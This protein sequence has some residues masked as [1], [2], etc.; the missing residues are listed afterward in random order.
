M[1]R[2]LRDFAVPG[3]MAYLAY[4][5]YAAALQSLFVGESL[6]R[7]ELLHAV[8]VFLSLRASASAFLW[9]GCAFIEIG[10]NDGKIGV[11]Q[12][13]VSSALV[14]AGPEFVLIAAIIAVAYKVIVDLL[15]WPNA[16]Q[17][18][19][20]A[21]VAMEL[22]GLVSFLVYEPERLVWWF[23]PALLACK[24]TLGVT[25]AR[26]YLCVTRPLPFEA[27]LF[28]L[29]VIL[30]PELF[31][32]KEGASALHEESILD[33]IR[34]EEATYAQRRAKEWLSGR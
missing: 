15:R 18:I 24:L 4:Y 8:F 7:P 11:E 1:K 30:L 34:F 32:A 23:F 27:Y 26:T 17:F 29:C 25:T 16:H 5:L 14:W 12:F 21:T 33:R 2:L 22:A 10:I 3:G 13:R 31:L 19:I 6:T 20:M 9:L 28:V